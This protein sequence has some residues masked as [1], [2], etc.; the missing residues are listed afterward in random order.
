MQRSLENLVIRIIARH[1]PNDPEQFS[2]GDEIFNSFSSR[3][4]KIKVAL[5]VLHMYITGT[6]L[7]NLEPPNPM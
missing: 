7:C 5:H 6:S 2:Q 3:R 1:L 4:Q